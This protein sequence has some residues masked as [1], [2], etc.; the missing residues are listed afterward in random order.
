[1]RL[2]CN[3]ILFGAFDLETALEHIAWAGFDGVELMGAHVRAC[4]EEGV[5]AGTVREMAHDHGLEVYSF[6]LAAEEGVIE[7]ARDMGLDLIASGPPGPHEDL[8][9]FIKSA[10]ELVPE[11]EQAGVRIAVKPHVGHP[12]YDTES[13]HRFMEGV[14]SPS[15]GIN[16]DPSHIFRANQLPEESVL[17]VGQHIVH[18]HFRDCWDAQDRG[19]GDP[20]LQVPG[21][22]RIDITATIKALRQ[23][24]YDGYLSLQIVGPHDRKEDCPLSR[25]VGIAAEG[26][27]YLRRCLEELD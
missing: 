8:E 15:F 23:V 25:V 2:G 19:P 5:P 1:M 10:R 21:R 9:T 26:K 24:G 4:M 6:E 13:M 7:Y 3:T 14:D 27:G 18:S 20:W 17:A 22:G 16:F 11:A 12:V